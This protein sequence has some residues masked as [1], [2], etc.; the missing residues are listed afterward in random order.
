MDTSDHEIS[1]DSE[2]VCNHCRKFEQE[3]VKNWHPDATG[4]VLWEQTVSRMKADGQ[5]KDYDCILGLSG[6]VD[7]SYLALVAKRAGLR[8]LAVHVDGGWNSE[9]AVSNIEKI[10]NYCKFDLQTV[11]IDWDM[12]R[13]LQLSY[14]KSSTPNQ[15]VPQ[16]HAFFA[17]LYY[18]ARQHKIR[19]V[20]SGGNIATEGIFP[21]SWHGAAADAI[22]LKAI[23]KKFG[24]RPL[25]NYRTVSFLEYYVLYPFVL[26]MRVV[27][28][29]N[30]MP[31]HK[32]TAIEELE[33][34][35]GWRSYGRKH[36]ESQ[37]TKLF[38]NYYLPRKFGF[39]KRRPHLSSLIVSGQMTRDQALEELEKPL[40]DPVELKQDLDYLCKKLRITTDEFEHLIEIPAR[41]HRDFP[42]W[43]GRRTL[44]LSALHSLNAIFGNRAGISAYRK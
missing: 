26:R 37:F 10:I 39:D 17:N 25:K 16:D 12:M 27:R 8:T 11:V 23:Q 38:Q 30:F 41:S 34:T 43:E 9:L 6:G 24:T 20:M 33:Q 13:D 5:G 14:L 36:G 2:G 44:L 35:I 4:A 31:Y 40:Y 21:S 1:F 32:Q 19:H 3:T 7:S 15:D 22:N 18:A 29:L 28:P 42:N